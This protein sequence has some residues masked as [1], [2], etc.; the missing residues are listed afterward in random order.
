M[1]KF[2]QLERTG[3][4][5]HRESRQSAPLPFNC[6]V[7]WLAVSAR[8]VGCSRKLLPDEDEI[9]HPQITSLFV[10][11]SSFKLWR[12]SWVALLLEPPCQP[13]FIAPD[14]VVT[15]S[16]KLWNHQLCPT[17][18]ISLSW[19]KTLDHLKD[20]ILWCYDYP[21]ANFPLWNMTKILTT[22]SSNF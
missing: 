6:K 18:I 12:Q 9:V 8:W 3:W 4:G 2:L 10:S 20:R 21:G 22:S 13:P 16:P 5:F 11:G 14:L 15:T 17:Q 1:P 19:I 7:P